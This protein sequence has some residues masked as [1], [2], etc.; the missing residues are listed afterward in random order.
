MKRRSLNKWVVKVGYNEVEGVDIY[1][2][3]VLADSRKDAEDCMDELGIEGEL[4]T[5]EE[6]ER[7]TLEG[8]AEKSMKEARK[9]RNAANE[10]SEKQ[11]IAD[12]RARRANKRP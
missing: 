9:A 1:T 10:A 3:L 8:Q 4:M 5:R 6:Y 7:D 2:G 12:A 11:R